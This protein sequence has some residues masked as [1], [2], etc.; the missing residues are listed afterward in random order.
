MN[1]MWVVFGFLVASLLPSAARADQLQEVVTAMV[2]MGFKQVGVL[3][4]VFHRN[5]ISGSTVG[6]LGPRAMTLPDELFEGLADRS[7]SSGNVRIIRPSMFKDAIKSRGLGAEDIGELS[8]MRELANAAG[9]DAI[10]I[11]TYDESGT[12]VDRHGEVELSGS[13]SRSGKL[14]VEIYD[15]SDGVKRQIMLK[16]TTTLSNAA[17]QGRSF[18]LRRWAENEIEN[19]GINLP[20]NEAFG[21]SETW[22]AYQFANLRENLQHPLQ[23]DDFA[24][25]IGIFVEQQRRQPIFFESKNGPSCVVELNGG[26][27]FDIRIKNKSGKPV[28]CA[29]YVDGICTT[30]TKMVEPAS[31]D[32]NKHWKMPADPNRNNVIRGWYRTDLPQNQSYESFVVVARDEAVALGQGIDESLGMVTAIFYSVGMDGFDE[33]NE[34]SSEMITGR[35]LSESAFGI[36]QGTRRKADIG[37]LPAEPRGIMLSAVTI[38]YRDAT[39][40]KMLQDGDDPVV[41]RPELATKVNEPET[42]AVSTQQD[43]AR[44]ETKLLGDGK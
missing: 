14:G 32:T 35:S 13:P 5:G 39:Q 6:E 41:A 27:E 19:V 37:R 31:L 38:H 8:A 30:I 20:N 40:L 15:P 44:D 25:D 4:V 3:P 28:Y 7:G 24:F 36:G 43:S 21:R 16:E 2:D 9:V 12:Q 26:E 17:F 34:M 10:V 23:L 11:M 1:R 18:E 22:E 33:P 29:L 42:P